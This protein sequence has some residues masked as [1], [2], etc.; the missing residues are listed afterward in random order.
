[1]DFVC[2]A[3]N[4]IRYGIYVVSCMKI[5]SL[6]YATECEEAKTRIEPD[7]SV[8]TLNYFEKNLTYL[9]NHTEIDRIVL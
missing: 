4:S 1:V 2:L 5:Y 9:R 8:F 6:P 7:L 3:A